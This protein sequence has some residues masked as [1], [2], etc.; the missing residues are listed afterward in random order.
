MCVNL[1]FSKEIEPFIK[2]GLTLLE[3]RC[4]SSAQ[5]IAHSEIF[6]L[7][8]LEYSGKKYPVTSAKMINLRGFLSLTMPVILQTHLHSLSA[9]VFPRLNVVYRCHPAQYCQLCYA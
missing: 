7:A 4:L 3:R 8:A 5:E 6:R 1:K 9:Q 2:I